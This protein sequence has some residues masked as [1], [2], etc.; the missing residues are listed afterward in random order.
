MLHIFISRDLFLPVWAGVSQDILSLTL[1]SI[2]TADIRSHPSSILST[3][4]DDACIL[5][6]HPDPIQ[7]SHHLQAHLSSVAT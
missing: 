2:Y 6:S 5:S 7:A 4:A 1:N 3:F